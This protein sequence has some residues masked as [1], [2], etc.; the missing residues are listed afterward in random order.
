MGR[1]GVWASLLP[2]ADFT[3]GFRAA[4][5]TQA[6]LG[7]PCSPWEGQGF[8]QQRSAGSLV[9]SLGFCPCFSNDTVTLATQAWPALANRDVLS[10]NQ[11]MIKAE[12]NVHIHMP[13][14][15][16]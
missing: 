3:L 15:N 8:G 11:Q 16:G 6:P 4:S 10:L 12:E 5:C 14:V 13:R 2:A 1:E 7:E 9:K